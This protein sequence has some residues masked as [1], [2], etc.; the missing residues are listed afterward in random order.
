MTTTTQSTYWSRVANTRATIPVAP[1]VFIAANEPGTAT[2][3]CGVTHENAAR[4]IA[5]GTHRLA[6]EPEVAQY[7]SGQEQRAQECRETEARNN[8]RPAMLEVARQMA[9]SF[10]VITDKQKKGDK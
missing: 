8:D 4:H 2:P 7:R 3:V 9:K 1:E 6:T 10:E 5:Q